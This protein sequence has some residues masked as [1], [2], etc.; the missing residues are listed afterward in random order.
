M[1]PGDSV[2]V[3]MSPNPVPTINSADGVSGVREDAGGCSGQGGSP[4]HYAVQ[5]Q[6]PL[7]CR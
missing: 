5:L 3:R 1:Q 6:P 4:G 2:R 7:V